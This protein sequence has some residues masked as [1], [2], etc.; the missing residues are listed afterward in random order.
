MHPK[1]SPTRWTLQDE[2]STAADPDEPEASLSL[3]HPFARRAGR[4]RIVVLLTDDTDREEIRDLLNGCSRVLAP[5]SLTAL[6]DE[7]APVVEPQGLGNVDDASPRGRRRRWRR[8]PEVPG[9]RQ[10]M[11]TIRPCASASLGPL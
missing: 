4:D 2:S 9:Q 5:K 3:G 1:N 10:S 7:F 8:I 6:L 11:S